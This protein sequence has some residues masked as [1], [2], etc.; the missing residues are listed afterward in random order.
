MIGEIIKLFTW[1]LFIILAWY[2]SYYAIRKYEEK[3]KTTGQDTN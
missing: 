3:N 2:L 1:P